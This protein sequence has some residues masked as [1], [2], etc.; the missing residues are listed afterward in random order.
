MKKMVFVIS[1]ISLIAILA[2][3]LV[4]CRQVK[5]PSATTEV[6]ATTEEVTKA[7]E[8]TKAVS[9]EAPSKERYV[10]VSIV[11]AHPFW[12]D[13]QE[14]GRDAAKQLGVTFEYTGPAEL[15]FAAQAS[16][17]EQVMATKPAGMMTTGHNPDAMVPVINK[18]IDAGIPVFTVDTDAPTS[19]RICYIGTNN[20]EAGI[21]MGKMVDKI[22]GG[23]GNIGISTQPGQFNLEE[24]IRGLEDYLKN[25]TEIKVVADADN[26]SDDSVAADATVAML[27]AHPEINLVT[28]MNATGAGVATAIRQ[29]GK[30][31]KVHAVVFDVTEPILNAVKDGTVDATIAQR[32]YL[33]TYLSVKLMYDYIHGNM[34]SMIG[35]DRGVIPLPNIID[36]GVVAVTKDNVDAYF[37]K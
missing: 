31:G 22:L 25:N 27:Q 32:T 15:D 16:T 30:V 4:S 37:R 23:K 33:F 14:G 29:T 13:A 18:A 36:T 21:F 19:K 12:I 6:T 5:I 9:E 17:F 3:L 35:V 11:S 28:S 1:M 26:K 2:I 10:F 8:E 24:R 7:T 20:Y 34:N